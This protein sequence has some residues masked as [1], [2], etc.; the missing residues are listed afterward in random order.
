MTD[1]YM[2]ADNVSKIKEECIEISKMIMETGTNKLWKP[3]K[4]LISRYSYIG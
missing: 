4:L 2:T 3:D 1:E